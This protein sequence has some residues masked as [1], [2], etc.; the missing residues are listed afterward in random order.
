M[1]EYSGAFEGQPARFKMTSVCGHVMTLDFL[2]EPRP[3]PFHRGSPGRA[4]GRQVCPG[5]VS[6]R[7]AGCRGLPCSPRSSSG[8]RGGQHGGGGLHLSGG[9]ARA[10]VVARAA[11]CRGAH[12][13]RALGS[14]HRKSSS[15]DPVGWLQARGRC[16]SDWGPGPRCLSAPR[17][18]GLRTAPSPARI[19]QVPCT[20]SLKWRSGEQCTG[21]GLRTLRSPGIRCALA[22]AS[23]VLGRES[24]QTVAGEETG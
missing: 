6:P 5:P 10:A 23:Q 12:C 7:P 18:E 14:W 21:R 19:V 8:P 20:P 24:V 2:G 13:L 9:L 15:S 3:P 16:G 17:V 4:R 1:H 11:T 22:R